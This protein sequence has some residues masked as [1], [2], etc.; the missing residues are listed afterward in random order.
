MSDPRVDASLERAI[1]GAL[2]STIHDHGPITLALVTS[3]VK[4]IV[5]NLANAREDVP[6][7]SG[8]PRRERGTAQPERPSPKG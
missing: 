5:G 3:A 8:T 2:R 6:D 7:A 4:R 1:A